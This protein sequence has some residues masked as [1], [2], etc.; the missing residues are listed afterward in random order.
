[1]ITPYYLISEKKLLKNCL[2]AERIQNSSGAKMLLALKCFSAWEMF[3]FMKP[4]LDGTTSSSLYEVRLGF[5]KFGKETH[6][7]CVGYTDEDMEWIASHPIDKIIFNSMSQLER[8]FPVIKKGG[9]RP[10]LGLRVNPGVSYSHYD[11]ADPNRANSRLGIKN[12]EAVINQAIENYGVDGLMFHFNCDNEDIDSLEKNTNHI[13]K[14]LWS[15]VHRIKWVSLG[16]GMLFTSKG[17]DVKRFCK[18]LKNFSIKHDVQV[19]LEPGE[20]IVHNAGYLVTSVVDIVHKKTDIAI[21]DASAEAHMLDSII[22]RISPEIEIPKKGKHEYVIAGRSCLAGDVFGQYSSNTNLAIGDK[23]WIANALSYTMVKRTWFNGLQPPS[24]VVER[25]NGKT[26]LVKE[27]SYSDF[28]Y[29][30]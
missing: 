17:F 4:Y 12:D 11:L 5:D 2:I 10:H 27:F 20:A 19:Y 9:L 14:M 15:Y 25:L 21:V 6:A 30:S 18:I 8:F 22:Y 1:V 7:Y 16:G 24:I 26:E 28:K 3:P 23:I 13:S 29:G